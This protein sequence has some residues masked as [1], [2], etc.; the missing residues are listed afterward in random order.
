MNFDYTPDLCD[1]RD[2]TFK[3]IRDQPSLV[4]PA[5]VDLRDKCL[6][7]RRQGDYGPGV[8]NALAGLLEYEF[9][10]VTGKRDRLSASFAYF[11]TQSRDDYV[12]NLMRTQLRSVLIGVK[13]FG[14]A[15]E[16]ECPTTARA[17]M[18][19]PLPLA[20][21]MAETRKVKEA[22]RLETRDDMLYCLTVGHPFLVG[23][24]VYSSFMSRGVLETG[25]VPMPTD[26]DELLGGHAAYCVGYNLNTRTFLLANSFGTEWGQGGF[27]TLPFEY[28]GNQALVRDAWMVKV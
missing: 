28:I 2:K 10:E 12:H 18:T 22:Y 27:F 3:E 24:S 17:I 23:F 20:Y 14:I 21:R 16:T 7:I 25:T 4:F 6:P 5:A 26:K 19:R 13:T 9:S 1:I 8:A 15:L 11:V